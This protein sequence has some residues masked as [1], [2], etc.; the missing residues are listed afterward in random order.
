MIIASRKNMLAV[1]WNPHRFHVV[2]MLPL[3]ASFNAVWLIDGTLSPLIGKFFP[4]GWSAARRKLV[5]HI[6]NASAHNSKTAQNFFGRN[7]LTKFPH[8]PYFPRSLHRGTF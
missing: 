2:P 5:V 4:A 1:L 7:Q 8:P 6:V 3:R